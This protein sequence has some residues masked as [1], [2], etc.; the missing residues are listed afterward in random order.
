MK[1]IGDSLIIETNEIIESDIIP[2]K[3]EDL[4]KRIVVK[5]GARVKGSIVGGIVELGL[6][7]A[8]EGGILA[9][10][11]K[12]YI[13]EIES[14]ERS[15]TFIRGDI[16]SL[17]NITF[18]DL[19]DR[20]VI[21][22]L[23][24]LIAPGCIRLEKSV[25]KGNIVSNRVELFD[26]IGMGLLSLINFERESESSPSKLSNTILFSILSDKPIEILGNIG[27]MAPVMYAPATYPSLGQNIT[28]PNIIYIDP[29]SL[30][31]SLKDDLNNMQRD[32]KKGN[33]GELIK[34]YL[35]KY[36][37]SKLPVRDLPKLISFLELEP[38]VQ[39]KLHKIELR[40]ALVK[41]LINMIG[42]S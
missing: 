35:E 17:S 16:T 41:T 26:V 37:I 21:L 31:E 23:G 38:F 6:G 27:V 3:R 15:F 9:S 7:C 36:Q 24:N 40:K 25:V 4:L 22:A 5:S 13:E 42:V 2:V 11:V 28:E 33:L 30:V 1:E 20:A 14:V 32:A 8:I 19:P 10:D 39:I 29:V 34:D 12:L 18:R